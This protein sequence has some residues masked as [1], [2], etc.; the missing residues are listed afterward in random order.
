[1]IKVMNMKLL[2]LLKLQRKALILRGPSGCGKTI[3]AKELVENAGEYSEVNVEEV[4]NEG[5]RFKQWLDNTPKTVIVEGVPKSDD[6][7]KVKLLIT[8]TGIQQER[9]YKDRTMLPTPMFIFCTGDDEP[10]DL[11][12]DDR[13]FYV[14]NMGDLND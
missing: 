14:I 2:E 3:L 10:I 11:L 5:S 6:I 9:K 12:S 7:G 8:S 4:L 13:R 1:M